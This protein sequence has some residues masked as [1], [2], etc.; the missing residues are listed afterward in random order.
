M[1]GWVEEMKGRVCVE[2]KV[3][4]ETTKGKGVEGCRVQARGQDQTAG[5]HGRSRCFDFFSKM[6]RAVGRGGVRAMAALLLLI[7]KNC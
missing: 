2:G 6:T 3:T 7:I 5:R 1:V 4:P